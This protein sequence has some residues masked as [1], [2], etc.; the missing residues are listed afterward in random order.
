MSVLLEEAEES[1][2][3]GQWDQAIERLEELR[4]SEEWSLEYY[5]KLVKAN[6]V[7]GHFLTV[8]EV[9]LEWADT[10]VESGNLEQAETALGYARGLRPDSTD[11]REMAI[12]LARHTAGPEEL[13]ARLV[14]LAHLHLEKGG[15]DRA[16]EQFRAVLR[17]DLENQDALMELARV[18][19]KKG[20]FRNGLLALNRVLQMNPES[21]QARRQMAELHLAAGTPEQAVREFLEAASLYNG[22]NETS[23][24][25]E[26]YRAVLRVD[27]ENSQA[28]N[29]LRGLSLQTEEDLTAD[30]FPPLTE[31]E[32]R[33][34]TISAEEESAPEEIEEPHL[35]ERPGLS[36]KR[37]ALVP[38]SQRAANSPFK[39]TL[40]S[41]GER[42]SSSRLRDGL[43]SR[44]SGMAAPKDS[45]PY[46]PREVL[47][48]QDDPTETHGQTD[49]PT[50]PNESDEPELLVRPEISE[51]EVE[52]STNL[53]FPFEPAEILFK[54]ED[55]EDIFE[56]MEDWFPADGVGETPDLFEIFDGE[57][58][59]VFETLVL[60]PALEVEAVPRLEV[61]PEV[62]VKPEPEVEP[63]PEVAPEPEFEVEPEVEPEPEPEVEP[64]LFQEASIFD[65]PMPTFDWESEFELDPD[66]DPDPDAS[67]LFPEPIVA[68]EEP[69]LDFESLRNA[70]I[71]RLADQQVLAGESPEL[72]RLLEDTLPQGY[73]IEESLEC[74][75]DP[76]PEPPQETTEPEAP[77]ETKLTVE[78]PVIALDAASRIEGYR[79]R[80]ESFPTEE[81]T[82]LALADTCLRYGL[83]EDALQYYR[84][85]QKANPACAATSASIIKT[86][87]WMEDVPT[88]KEELWKAAS[89]SFDR[90]DLESCQDRLGDLLSLDRDHRDARRLMVEVFLAQGQEKL[91]CWHLG[92]IVERAVV[93]KAYER[94]T[95]SLKRLHD[96]S[97]NETVLE[98]LGELYEKQERHLEA[99]GIFRQLRTSYAE[100]ERFDDA[101]RLARLAVQLEPT[102]TS[103]REVLIEL[104]R[105]GCAGEEVSEQQ[106]ELAELYRHQGDLSG[107]IELLQTIQ[108]NNPDRLDAERLLVE[109]HLQNRSYELAEQH[110]E[111]LAERFL[112]QK[113]YFRAI[114]LFEY[115]VGAAPASSRARERLAQFYQLNGA[116]EEAKMEWF[117]AAES[118]QASGDFQRAALALD[119]ALELDPG[120]A[121]WRLR[122][123]RIRSKNLG[124]IEEAL[125]EYRRLFQADP[126][127]RKATVDYLD[128]LVEQSRLAEAGEVLL[129][130]ERGNPGTELKDN[131]VQRVKERMAAE[132]DDL[133]L[134]FGWGELCLALEMLD[135]AIE[136]F[137]RLR[138]DPGYQLHSYRLLGLCFSRKKGFNMVELALSQF[139]RGLALEGQSEADRLA[140]R[141]DLAVVLE[142]HGRRGEALEQ[143]Q[144]IAAE[145]PNY[146]DVAKRLG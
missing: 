99:L 2:S 17:L 58:E 59:S 25:V 100:A 66:P 141:Y 116:L 121:E 88:V 65:E 104:L 45:K 128:L 27:A 49:Q 52:N 110:A 115:W 79:D 140:L 13:A 34:E 90:G 97:P 123:A 94:A 60:E 61:E 23:M 124:L 12:K 30:L 135:L 106:L 125:Q 64:E 81:K 20:L 146:R 137:Q 51:L 32:P 7:R 55:T 131:V 24:A 144:I 37:P 46:F 69:S 9:Y 103:D 28:L 76:N 105:K 78:V 134:A 29:A 1:I 22:S 54:D 38:K 44:A 36:T 4:R 85:V 126:T 86:A 68:E 89:S 43:I 82:M 119:R 102:R 5:P 107:A 80:L 118:H 35:F 63:E 112:E 95:E 133:A 15:G 10:A 18:C 138:R 130:V 120:Q 8:L 21:A 42:K 136:Q 109:L 98:R 145:D 57:Q 67:P 84:L 39:P 40:V 33:P 62:E 16:E 11:V 14:E 73:D 83:L 122:L 3:S 53:E 72:S 19:Q 139:Q 132:P 77:P 50:L 108:Q 75:E 31:E 91:A 129:Q 56:G 93:E 96:I 47:G 92:Q 117:Q 127:W 143:L 71:S 70:E 26:L 74:I 41:S 101:V 87:L 111:S 48:P 6:A 114:E 113:A 142:T